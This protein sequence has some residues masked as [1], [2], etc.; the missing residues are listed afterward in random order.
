M[1]QHRQV[2]RGLGACFV[3]E[4]AT[5][6]GR[7]CGRYCVRLQWPKPQPIANFAV[8][9]RAYAMVPA[10][11][12][13]PR[14]NATIGGKLWRHASPSCARVAAMNRHNIAVLVFR[15]IDHR[16]LRLQPNPT[17]QRNRSS[18]ACPLRSKFAVA[19]AV[20]GNSVLAHCGLSSS[21]KVMSGC[22]TLS[23]TITPSSSACRYR[24]QTT[25]Q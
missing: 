2:L 18:C 22:S 20:V 7:F 21:S 6:F 13:E 4:V 1:Q 11:L 17:V 10:N 15:E 25:H 9:Q 12:A 16:A 3:G 19:Q 8:R 24:P 14:R 23:C 5:L